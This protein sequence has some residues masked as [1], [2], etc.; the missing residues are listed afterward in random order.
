M[1]RDEVRR[2]LQG[3]VCTV[4]TP[5]D[6][7]FEV[8]YGRM[9][10]LT[11]WWMEQGLVKG[12]TI[13]KVAAGLGE[14]PMLSDDEWPHLLRTVV[15]ASNDKAAIVCG[16]QYKDTKRTIEDAK[17]AQDLGAIV[18]Q[19]VPPVFN[20]P[21]QDDL[22]DYFGELS[23]A[24]DIG[25]LIYH[26]HWLLGGTIAT[27]TFLK[28]AGFEHVVGVKWSTP[29]G[30][31]YEDMAKFS[32]TF[33]VIDNT[34]QP[35]RCHRLGGRG[36]VQTAIESYPPHDLKVWELLESKQ[37]EEAQAIYD[38]VMKPL[39]AFYDKVSQRSGGQARTM[40]GL[41]AV[42]GMPVGSSRPP[43]KPLNAEEMAELRELAIGW[44]W[45]VPSSSG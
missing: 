20:L 23:D 39:R 37:Y 5:F 7:G 3:P 9:Y 21:T 2:L 19:V 45:P 36:Y 33:N 18:L 11:Q 25:I 32:D 44:G 29:D 1:Q 16:L 10:E 24:I 14:G 13:I 41:M 26:T 40:K 35:V 17:R 38:S 43:S 6:D 28:M 22:L 15:Q 42:M 34:M 4:P 30:V 31:D 8:D 12:K 27:E